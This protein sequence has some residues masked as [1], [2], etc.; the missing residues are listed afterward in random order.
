MKNTLSAMSLTAAIA[1]AAACAPSGK[2]GSDGTLSPGSSTDIGHGITLTCDFDKK[3]AIGTVIV[4]VR[5]EDARGDAVDGLEI[6]GNSGMP[7]MAGAHDSG[8][9]PFKKNRKGVFLL[10]V[11]VVMPG[12]WEVGIT[13]SRDGKQLYRGRLRFNV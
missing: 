1:I 10:P 5:A 9:V 11:N 4:R 7:E 3:P 2:H 13:V 6:T 12:L 8:D